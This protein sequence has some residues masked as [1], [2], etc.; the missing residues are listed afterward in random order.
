MANWLPN[1]AMD[2]PGIAYFS[3]TA[4]AA[5]AAYTAEGANQAGHSP[6]P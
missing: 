3:H 1:V 6:R 4:N 5:E 2:G